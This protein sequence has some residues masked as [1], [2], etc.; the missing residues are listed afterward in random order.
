[1]GWTKERMKTGNWESKNNVGICNVGWHNT[2]MHNNGFYNAG[3]RNHGYRNT[4]NRNAGCQNVGELN[5]GDG[6]V[7]SF[8]IGDYNL[9]EYNHTSFSA[10]CFCTEQP[11]IYLFNK[12][13]DWTY[14]D[15]MDSVARDIL[16]E[17]NLGAL[18]WVYLIYLSDE[19]KEIHPEWVRTGGCLKRIE[20]YTERQA[21]WDNLEDWKKETIK[22]IPNFDGFIFKKNYR[23]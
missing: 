3:D 11:K 14:L 18:E 8:N 5:I 19:E 22:A 23:D 13:S 16:S 21:W 1:M 6:N 2:G 15:W 9:G 4:G 7:G 10:G 12:L 17:I 20:N